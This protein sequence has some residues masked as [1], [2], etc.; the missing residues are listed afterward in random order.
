MNAVEKGHKN[1]ME[2]YEQKISNDHENTSN[3]IITTV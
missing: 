2:N 1:M 3:G